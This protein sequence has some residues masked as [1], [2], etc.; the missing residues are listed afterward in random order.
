M[1][2]RL[3]RALNDA[4]GDKAA[5]VNLFCESCETHERLYLAS[6]IEC[7]EEIILTCA[8]C[9]SAASIGDEGAVAL[10]DA[11]RVN[12]TATVVNIGSE[13]PD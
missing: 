2:T 6:L 10:S 13:L 11:L 8:R 9:L 1:S 7:I 4:L 5:C 12:K 3:E